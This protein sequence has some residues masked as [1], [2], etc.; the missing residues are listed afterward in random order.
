MPFDARAMRA[1]AMLCL[2][3][4]ARYADAALLRVAMSAV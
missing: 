3:Y 2:R 4:A 1:Y